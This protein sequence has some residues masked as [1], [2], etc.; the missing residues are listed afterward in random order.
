MLANS[1]F[2]LRHSNIYANLMSRTGNSLDMRNVCVVLVRAFEQQTDNKTRVE[3]KYV[4]L[5]LMLLLLYV[6][7]IPLNLYARFVTRCVTTNELTGSRLWKRGITFHF[8]FATYHFTLEMFFIL[9]S[10]VCSVFSILFYAVKSESHIQIFIITWNIFF[11]SQCSPHVFPPHFF[12]PRKNIIKALAHENINLSREMKLHH[13]TMCFSS[14]SS[15]PH[16]SM[17]WLIC[18]HYINLYE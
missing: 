18:C 9:S 4:L 11:L 15:L 10:F 14:L 8:T 1:R 5:K 7:N 6:T 16:R 13:F 12:L 2:T 3:K 17:C